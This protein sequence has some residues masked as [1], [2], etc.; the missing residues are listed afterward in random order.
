MSQVP[1]PTLSLKVIPGL[2][3]VQSEAAAPLHVKQVKSHLSQRLVTP[4]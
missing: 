3:E 1:G 2:Q 4:L